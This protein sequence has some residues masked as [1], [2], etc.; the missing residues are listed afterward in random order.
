[1]LYR[2][3]RWA[4]VAHP[5]ATEVYD[6]DTDPRMARP[7]ADVPPEAQ[8]VVA[9]ARDIPVFATGGATADRPDAATVER[10]RT[11]GYVQ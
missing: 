3:G 5:S 10:L 8:E 4:A 6:L 9:G 2:Q 11:L 1:M 7:L